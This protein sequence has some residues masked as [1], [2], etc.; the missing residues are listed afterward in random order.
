[1]H[2]G[3]GFSCHVTLLR[4]K[5]R[6]TV[7]LET[8][9][10]FDAPRIDPCFLSDPTD[11]PLLMTG[12]NLQRSLLDAAPFA[13]YRDK[14][15]YEL[16][17]SDPRA[18]EQDIRNRADTQYHPVGTCKMG[19]DKRSVVDDQL[20]VHGLQGLRVA[21]ASIMPTLIGGN[22]NA[23]TIMIAEKAADMIRSAY[24]ESRNS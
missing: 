11:L 15:L 16:D 6:G 1:M 21:D 18:V 20:R 4:P 24:W 7:S 13:P 19:Q 14:G 2:L 22:T 3:H 8:P 10:P 17:Q 23:P 12:A 9:D 5:S